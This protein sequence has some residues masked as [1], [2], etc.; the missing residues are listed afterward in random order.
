MQRHDA[1][2]VV[3]GALATSVEVH[4]ERQVERV[5]HGRPDDVADEQRCS[6]HQREVAAV[7]GHH[8]EQDQRQQPQRQRRPDNKASCYVNGNERPYCCC[9][10]RNKSVFSFLRQLTTWHCPHLI[11]RAVL[12]RSCC[13][14]PGSN[15]SI[16]PVRRA[17]SSKP[18]VSTCGR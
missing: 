1:A 2:G 11:L 3:A 16:S 5:A 10:L 12:R 8:V 4:R 6:G 7:A 9:S 13:W 17:H 18:A 15:R 14:A